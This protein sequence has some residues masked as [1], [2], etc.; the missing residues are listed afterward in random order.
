MENRTWAEKMTARYDRCLQTGWSSYFDKIGFLNVGYWRGIENSLEMA[1]INLIETLV[2]FFHNTDGNVL[3]VACGNG[4]S[5]KFLTKYFD[6]KRITGINISASQ[7]ERCKVFAP[8]CEFKLMDATKLGF[9][10]SSY[11]NVLCIEAAFHFTTRLRYFEE[12]YR[13]LKPS[14]RMAMLDILFDYDLLESLDSDVDASVFPRENYL[15]NL[16]AYREGLLKVGF[17]HVRVD[18]CTVLTGN[19]VCKYLIR[20]LERE[21]GKTEDAKLFERIR[22]TELIYKACSPWCMVYAVK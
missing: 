18:D 1:Q 2:S 13:V 10:S 6:A 20:L 9:E 3:D 5:T 8:E 19:A 7:L 15:P 12:A 21:F 17:R 14:G 11:D 22:T 16:D 4:A